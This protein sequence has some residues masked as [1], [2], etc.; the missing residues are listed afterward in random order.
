MCSCYA[1]KLFGEDP[2]PPS[3]LPYLSSDLKNKK[4]T[5]TFSYRKSLS[6]TLLLCI[7]KGSELLGRKHK[8]MDIKKRP[9][10]KSITLG[11][12]F[13][14]LAFLP[15]QPHSVQGLVFSN[16][17]F[18]HKDSRWQQNQTQKLLRF[19]MVLRGEAA[20]G[21]NLSS[22]NL[23]SGQEQKQNIVRNWCH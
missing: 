18:W 22:K 19:Q 4:F 17:F 8:N 5:L 21:K 1:D 20:F 6:D 13:A 7:F 16:A 15:I 11:K 9:K 12:T 14:E 2:W 23:N 3:L 10:Y